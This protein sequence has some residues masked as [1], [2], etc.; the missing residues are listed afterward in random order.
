MRLFRPN[1]GE[2]AP[3][4]YKSPEAVIPKA[5]PLPPSRKINLIGVKSA[6]GANREVTGIIEAN[7][8]EVLRPQERAKQNWSPKQQT[9]PGGAIKGG[10]ARQHVVSTGRGDI[11]QHPIPGEHP[12]AIFPLQL[13]N[14][15]KHCREHT[16]PTHVR[17]VL[18]AVL[19]GQ[20]VLPQQV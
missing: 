14:P 7:C 9:A 17:I 10:S 4:A 16:L 19:G 11:P 2:A 13:T 3:Q 15:G 8:L 12:V 6:P 5:T 1:L 20:Q 18:A